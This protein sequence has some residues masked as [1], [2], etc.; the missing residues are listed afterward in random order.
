VIRTRSRRRSSKRDRIEVWRIILWSGL[1]NLVLLSAFLG[2]QHFDLATF[3]ARSEKRTDMGRWGPAA[4]ISTF[5][6]TSKGDFSTSTMIVAKTEPDAEALDDAAA[7]ES[8]ADLALAAGASVD[9]SETLRAEPILRKSPRDGKLE[10]GNFKS[11][12]LVGSSEE[13]LDFGAALLRDS[14][15]A[16]E[17]LNVVTAVDEITIVRICAANGSVIITCRGEQIAVSPR[18]AR[19]DDQCARKG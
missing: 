8:T 5:G 10:I 7:E 14:G 2:A 4:G 11:L 18:K 6:I 19:P 15:V 16:N 3:G 9:D 12:S 13:C 17:K 1:T